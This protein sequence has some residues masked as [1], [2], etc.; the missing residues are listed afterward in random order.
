MC[1]GNTAA[2]LWFTVTKSELARCAPSHSGYPTRAQIFFWPK[3][4]HWPEVV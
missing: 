2:T 3:V 1:N 4:S